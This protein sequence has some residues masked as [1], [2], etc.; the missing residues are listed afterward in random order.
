MDHPCRLSLIGLNN[1]FDCPSS[2]FSGAFLSNTS[3]PPTFKN[4]S[5]SILKKIFRGV[6]M[7]EKVFQPKSDF[8]CEINVWVDEIFNYNI[9]EFT[10]LLN[11]ENV[12]R[13]VISFFQM[14]IAFIDFPQAFLTAY[15]M[16]P[17]L[18]AD[19]TKQAINSRSLNDFI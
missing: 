6:E 19:I 5:S 14:K 18:G 17:F 12:R 4:A 15:L 2:E 11:H 10:R 3:N 16:Q 9:I 13:F 7:L 8:N 1:V